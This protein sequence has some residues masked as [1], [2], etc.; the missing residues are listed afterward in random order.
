MNLFIYLQWGEERERE[1][2]TYF[3]INSPKWHKNVPEVQSQIIKYL[4]AL[5]HKG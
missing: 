4:S 2:M 1:C 5:C 3:V